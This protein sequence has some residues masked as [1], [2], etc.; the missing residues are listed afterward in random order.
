MSP[1]WPAVSARIGQDFRT[2]GEAAI[3]ACVVVAPISRALPFALIPESP[4]MEPRSTSAAGQASRTF[5]AGSRLCPPARGRAPFFFRSSCVASASV[6]GRKYSK[7]VE[8]IVGLLLPRVPD[9]APDLLRRER[10]VDR[11]DVKRSERVHDGV[12]DGDRRGDGARLADALDAQRI[13]GRRRFRRPELEV[14]EEV[15]LGHGVVHHRS[16]EKLAALVVGGALPEGLRDSLGDA[17]V[18]LAADDHRVDDLAAVVD[19]DVALEMD[20]AGLRV[21]AN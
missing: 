9:G 7:L 1:I 15:G 2:S 3:S 14:R 18:D 17:A 6:L 16:G 21:H 11:A 19:G 13:D 12:V 20:L 8:Y 5:M 4:F 10:H